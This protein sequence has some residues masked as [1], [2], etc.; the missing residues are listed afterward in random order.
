LTATCE[1]V[2]TLLV[3]EKQ[4]KCDLLDAY[5]DKLRIFKDTKLQLIEDLKIAHGHAQL[6]T[7][8]EARVQ[9]LESDL[10]G[11]KG[12]VSMLQ[13]DHEALEAEARK[14]ADL[15]APQVEGEPLIG[16][17]QHL[18]AV[19]ARFQASM[20]AAAHSCTCH[21]LALVKTYV[22]KLDLTRLV[23][24]AARGTTSEAFEALVAEAA[25]AADGILQ[26]LGGN[27]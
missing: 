8:L 4:S 7:E 5:S 10:S 18:K 14:V 19:P 11:E 13:A 21:V 3:E 23:K 6:I 12:K 24:G 1:Q 16:L 2:K 9:T 27:E 26:N 17:L 22:P 15:V 25:P 20:T